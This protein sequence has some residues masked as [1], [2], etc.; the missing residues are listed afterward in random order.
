MFESKN[1]GH[2]LRS[3]KEIH[4]LL[5]RISKDFTEVGSLDT[6]PIF[7]TRIFSKSVEA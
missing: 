5:V 4:S 2:I 7:L 1:D 3:G 6:A